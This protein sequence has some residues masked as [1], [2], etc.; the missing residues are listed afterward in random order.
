MET[1]ELM[2]DLGTEP[3]LNLEN[4]PGAK[5]FQE[6]LPPAKKEG[7]GRKRKNA[8]AEPV[9]IEY[10]KIPLLSSWGPRYAAFFYAAIFLLGTAGRVYPGPDINASHCSLSD[11]CHVKLKL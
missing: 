4:V 7:R 2:G 3:D 8:E 1:F 10:Y 6:P 9:E 11:E 5:E